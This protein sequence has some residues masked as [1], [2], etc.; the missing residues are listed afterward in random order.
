VTKYPAAEDEGERKTR[1]ENHNKQKGRG[2]GPRDQDDAE[3]NQGQKKE[4]LKPHIIQQLRPVPLE[5]G[6]MMMQSPERLLDI[7]DSR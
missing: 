7:S 1:E 6:E 5:A 3:R 2:N 4:I